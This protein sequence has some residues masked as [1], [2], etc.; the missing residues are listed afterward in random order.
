[1][2]ASVVSRVERVRREGWGAGRS[3]IFNQRYALPP[4]PDIRVFF[5]LSFFRFGLNHLR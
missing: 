3:P 5:L 2:Q 4:P 1:V